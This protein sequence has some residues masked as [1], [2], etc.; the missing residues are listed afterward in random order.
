M[1]RQPPPLVFR[2]LLLEACEVGADGHD[3]GVLRPIARLKDRQRAAHER[4]GLGRPVHGLQ[5]QREILEAFRDATMLGSV[6]GLVD[7]QRAAPDRLGL[8]Q[9]VGGF[10]QPGEVVEVSRD[11]GMLGSVAGLVDR[12]RAAHERLGFG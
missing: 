4:L 11:V 5:Q 8:G 1:P 7:R 12:Q 6:A 10:Q 2:G 3:I 9:P